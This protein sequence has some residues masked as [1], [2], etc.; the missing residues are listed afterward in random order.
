MITI[1]IVLNEELWAE[2]AI[3]SGD[4]G[5]KPYETICRVAKYYFH[6]NHSKKEVRGLLDSFLLK[7]NPS[8]S[9]TKWSDTLDYAVS[10]AAKRKL[11]VA[12]S[13]TITEPEI[14]RIRGLSGAQLQR[15]AFT[16][17][18]LAKY[19]KLA[20]P[21]SDWWV[22]NDDSEVMKL[23]NINTSIKRQCLLY[24]DLKNQNMIQF[25]KKIDNTNVRV[26]F[27][28]S[29][30]AALEITDFR[31]LGNQYQLYL[32]DPKFIKCES[33]GLV[34]R[35]KNTSPDGIVMVGRKQKY[36]DQCAG[37]RILYTDIPMG[38]VS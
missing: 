25:S 27:S 3:E 7:C 23:A 9:L 26:L 2:R 30:K 24:H 6:Q 29:G 12:D 22:N 8:V 20:N 4:M 13:I 21:N 1:A 11:L 31:N 19:W 5:K 16:L 35:S 28:Q 15:L 36:C 18:C 32:G 33:C 38:V 10:V 17:L 37:K 14:E 34:I